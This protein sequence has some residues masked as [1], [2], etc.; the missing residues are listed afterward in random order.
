MR[1]SLDLSMAPGALYP[2]I[3]V[4]PIDPLISGRRFARPTN[5]DICIIELPH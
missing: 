4:R 1:I 3:I 5:P 2:P